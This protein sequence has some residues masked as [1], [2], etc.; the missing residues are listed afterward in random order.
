MPKVLHEL[1]YLTEAP[2]FYVSERRAAIVLSE[3]SQG[4][5]YVT[6]RRKDMFMELY[7]RVQALMRSMPEMNLRQS[8]EE[9]I[10]Q[11]APSFYLTEG[12]IAVILSKAKRQAYEQTLR[13]LSHQF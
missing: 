7:K 5:I 9:I 3:I 10:Y 2:R 13:R 11:P 4:I 1:A 6:G 8:C 12:T